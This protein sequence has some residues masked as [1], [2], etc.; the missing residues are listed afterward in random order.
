MNGWALF[1][2]IA[3]YL[4]ICVGIGMLRGLSRARVRTIAILVS[5]ILALIGTLIVKNSLG[6]PQEIEATLR[7]AGLDKDLMETISTFLGMS[8]SL[9]EALVGVIGALI[10][11]L[12]YLV[13][14]FTFCLLTWIVCIILSIVLRKRYREHNSRARMKWL[15]TI[16]LSVL[17]GLIVVFVC[18]VPLNIYMQVAVPVTNMLDESG[19]LDKVPVLDKVMDDYVE[20][21]AKSGPMA[22]FR[23]LGGNLVCNGLTSFEVGG[24]KIRLGDE[25]NN[26]SG[27]VGNIL[28]LGKVK[29]TEYGDDQVKVLDDIA[30]SFASSQLLSNIVG[31]VVYSATDAWMGGD[32]FVGVARPST[33]EMIDPT[34][35]TL[36]GIL[37]KD[38][39]NLSSLK[40]D[41][42]TV[43]DLVGV[44]A[45]YDVFSKMEDTNTLIQQLGADG[46]VKEM[47]T[48]LGQND[49]MKVLIVEIRNMGMRAI[50]KTLDIPEN[51]EVVYE[52]FLGDIAVAL[53]ET[54]DMNETE[55]IDTLTQKVKDAFNEANVPIEEDIIDCYSAS[56]I[57]DLGAIE[58]ITSDDISD[59]FTAYAMQT[60][61]AETA[62]LVPI[63]GSESTFRG[64]VYGNMTE[65]DLKKTGAAVLA[66]VTIKLS[67]VEGDEQAVIE[68][69]AT[70]LK[71]TYSE[72]LD[73]N[74]AAFEKIAQIE[75]KVAIDKSAVENTASM[76]A[77]QTMNSGVVTLEEL[78]AD[79]EEVAKSI[80][81]ET[82]AAEAEALNAVF[83]DM[84][85]LMDSEAS[86]DSVEDVVGTLGPVLDALQSSVSMGEEGTANLLVATMQSKTVREKTNMDM[87]AATNL[88]KKAT[89]S[90][91]GE[92]VDYE[93]T[94]NSVVGVVIIGNS[95]ST[96]EMASEEDIRKMIENLTPQTAA[97]LSEYVTEARMKEYGMP[98]DKAHV[99]SELLLNLFDYLAGNLP[100][101]QFDHEAKALQQ[102]INIATA[103]KEDSSNTNRVFG[104]DG[105]LGKDA[106]EIIEIVIG[107]DAICY[108]LDE[109]LNSEEDA[110]TDPFGIGK[111]IPDNSV[112]KMEYE[113]AA[114]AYLAAHPDQET[115]ER[116]ALINALFGIN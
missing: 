40:A 91:D 112:D 21:V 62:G 43:A 31:E 24:E 57:H 13:L 9:G 35:N 104:K 99:S 54:K 3:I 61:S 73:E 79:V 25:V 77:A 109:T 87:N 42:Y 75:I 65:E 102:L 74:A 51:G 70:I 76:K 80:N 59:F 90:K 100:E 49:S 20:P 45:E 83:E 113:A 37:N 103:A 48:V 107:S 56:L 85:K 110:I 106:S 39:Q 96:G 27:F 36:L 116:M 86:F 4:L 89:E 18:L 22:T 30:D 60:E 81:A 97:L 2:V 14:F 38:S 64:N 101:D 19:M 17:H 29:M 52:K 63:S 105:K 55:R 84:S 15:R 11:P 78:L 23:V 8:P 28:A 46:M 108:A 1:G 58:N 10:L 92:K 66:T 88:A 72:I 47:I 69:S 16:A 6:T 5:G 53:N 82:L 33:G 93:K 98:A 67:M 44:L 26:I 95:I 12:V 115:A 114:E 7:S 50:A 68:A 34:F 32:K 111:Q 71:E 94:M 41:I